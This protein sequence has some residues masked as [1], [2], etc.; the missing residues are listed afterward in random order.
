MGW[1]A[2]SGLGEEMYCLVRKYIPV[3]KRKLIAGK[4]YDLV[5]DQDADD[6][7]GTTRLEKDAG[8]TIDE[9]EE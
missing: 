4:I 6:W 1:S 2:G 3:N 7:D 5:C 8:M 9:D